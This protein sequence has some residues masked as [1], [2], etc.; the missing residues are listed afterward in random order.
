MTVLIVMVV[1]LVNMIGQTAASIGAATGRIDAG[2]SG[3]TMVDRMGRDL[4]LL[5]SQGGATVV[6]GET[7]TGTV[8]DQFIAFLSRIRGPNDTTGAESPR[9]TSLLYAVK[10]YEDKAL[11]VAGVPMLWRA[12]AGVPWENAGS[13]LP[14]DAL[15]AMANNS[16]LASGTVA[17]FD[18]RILRMAMAVQVQDGTFVTVDQA[19]RMANFASNPALSTNCYPLDL[20]RVKAVVVAVAVLDVD[21]RVKVRSFFTQIAQSLP[22]PVAGKTPM[23]AW[24]AA[25]DGG[26][27][28]TLPLP[29]R[30]NI[31]FYQR[32][33]PLQ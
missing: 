32:I 29:V 13:S 19:P 20:T 6:V 14:E 2:D 16:R 1:M 8:P 5:V 33:F 30:Q 17:A 7:S 24:Q 15:A 23:D 9:L 28:N 18:D 22:V 25:V 26:S 10:P 3:R 12:Y 27:L 11:K 31:R 21:T 4:Q